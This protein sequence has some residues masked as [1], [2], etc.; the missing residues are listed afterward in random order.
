VTE[1][2]F[3]CGGLSQQ[4]RRLFTFPHTTT[5]CTTATSPR[6][7]PPEPPI[8][9]LA[10]MSSDWS[11]IRRRQTLGEVQNHAMASQI[12]Q[13]TSVLK[14]SGAGRASVAPGGFAG[15][16]SAPAPRTSLAPQRFFRSSSGGNL[17]AEAAAAPTMSSSQTSSQRDSLRNSRQSY[18][19][20]NSFK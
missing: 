1:I 2:D 10:T 20:Q 9:A 4:R 11:A 15:L 8:P 13:P 16:G 12:P 5:H 19:P 14:K 6:V 3:V 18:A 17:A 7:H